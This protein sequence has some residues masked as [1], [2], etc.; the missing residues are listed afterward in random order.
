MM[1]WFE[2]ILVVLTTLSGLVWLLDKLFLAKRRRAAAGGGAGGHAEHQRVVGVQHRPA[3]GG[4]PLAQGKCLFA[5]SALEGPG[6][7][8]DRRHAPYRPRGK[9]L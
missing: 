8:D 3:V 4:Q 1:V 7:F 2:T 9:H 6:I 5:R